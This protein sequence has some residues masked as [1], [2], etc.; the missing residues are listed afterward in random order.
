MDK[1]R[2]Q[3]LT[4][5]YVP[6]LLF[7]LSS[8]KDGRNFSRRMLEDRQS[9]ND[10]LI[11]TR[12]APSDDLVYDRIFLYFIPV[13]KK[14]QRDSWILIENW[15]Y[16]IDP[17]LLR[18]NFPEIFESI[19]AQ[20][21]KARKQETALHFQ[22]PALTRLMNSFVRQE[23]RIRI[24]NPF[25][26]LASF[27]FDLPKETHYHGQ[28]INLDSWVLG[29]LRLMAHDKKGNT[30]FECA[31]SITAW[32]DS[33][34]KYDY[35]ICN[36]PLRQPVKQ[37][38]I[39]GKFI[40]TYL[41]TEQFVV[42]KALDNLSPDGLLVTMVP[43]SFLERK[44]N[45]EHIITSLVQKRLI[46]TLVLL[47][48]GV[49]IYTGLPLAILVL[50]KSRNESEYITMVDA[51]KFVS[52][53]NAIYRALD[54]EKLIFQINSNKPNPEI[55]KHIS[56]RAVVDND[57]DLSI[58]RYF[59]KNVE[60]E[61]L[62]KI[63]APVFPQNPKVMVKAGKINITDLKE[64]PVDFTILESDL[65]IGDSD[66]NGF[67][68]IRE[69]C[70]LVARLGAKLKPSY[71]EYQGQPIL[72]SRNVEAYSV[73]QSAV[74]IGYLIVELNSDYVTEQLD[75]FRFGNAIPYIRKSDFLKIVIKL[76]RLKEQ[77]AKFQGIKETTAQINKLK[78][79]RNA[80][81]HE[82]QLD[83]FNEFASLKHTL[84][85]PRQNIQ[86]WAHNL[87]DFF[88]KNWD[89]YGQLNRSFASIYK[90]DIHGALSQIKKDINFIT[91]VLENGENGLVLSVYPNSYIS[92]SRLNEIIN[93]IADNG[94]RFKIT[95][96][97][98][99][100]DELDRRGIFANE[101]LLKILLDNIMTN[102]NKHGF[103]SSQQ[104]NE[105]VVE[106]SESAEAILLEIRNNGKQFPRNFDKSKFTAKFST[107]DS[108]IGSGLGGYDINR[109]ATAFGNPDW[110]LALNE[111]PIYP[112]KFKFSFPIQTL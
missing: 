19:L 112:V 71:F 39:T 6:V 104:G 17:V 12:N 66:E 107:A 98:I 80:L 54:D 56:Y 57:Y 30:L 91:E 79:E 7:L 75:A 45:S 101:V 28:E 62:G 10:N 64:N 35:I 74:D 8:Y 89:G 15:L 49:Q 92:L 96:R 22:P 23:N 81:V 44:R 109:I 34:E 58:P 2:G 5:E 84:G 24:F 40:H 61:E 72:L 26:G 20:L 95:S 82:K 37:Y 73:N 50:G 59:L 76:P 51:R 18:A 4:G 43:L 46:R 38:N 9:N 65:A 93:D 27:G 77:R 13:L 90:T 48:G 102:A 85:R 31:D 70:L 110:V 87:L 1:L 36:M 47:P 63:L 52:A 67:S 3:I 105:V 21:S 106:L 14:I 42:E 103:A 86:D 29:Q 33:E 78:A 25:A 16:R 55:I 99:E 41:W 11:L 111:D 94:L 83:S 32:P 108:T 100:I 53:D 88:T 97:P 68:L 69:S 60:G